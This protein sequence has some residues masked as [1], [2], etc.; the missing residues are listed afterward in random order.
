M[1]RTIKVRKSWG[2]VN[3]VSHPH[4][5]PKGKKEYSRKENRR[6]EKESY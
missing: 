2:L 1:K 5:P 6:I 4:S 3:P